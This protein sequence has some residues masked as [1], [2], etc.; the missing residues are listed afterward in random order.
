MVESFPSM[1][2]TQHYQRIKKTNK[3]LSK[4][5]QRVMALLSNL[6]T[7]VPPLELRVEERTDSGQ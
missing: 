7:T 1:L 6:T 5:Y 2:E 3:V 4:M